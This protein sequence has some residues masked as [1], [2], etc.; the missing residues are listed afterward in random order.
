MSFVDIYKVLLI[1]VTKTS[2]TFLK[3]GKIAIANQ[4]VDG[5]N[6]NKILDK[7]TLAMSY[8]L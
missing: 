1:R 3:N 5:E 4:R 7:T 2:V 8:F 6:S